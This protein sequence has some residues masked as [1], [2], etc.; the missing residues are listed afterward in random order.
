MHLPA[1]VN[2]TDH[3]LSLAG[4]KGV[5]L[6]G[7]KHIFPCSWLLL[8]ATQDTFQHFG[9]WHVKCLFFFKIPKTAKEVKAGLW[10]AVGWKRRKLKSLKVV[11]YQ[12][13]SSLTTEAMLGVHSSEHT[14][15]ARKGE[16]RLDIVFLHERVLS[17]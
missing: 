17:L 8:S 7:T 2:F 5:Q 16:Q 9:F 12:K 4:G 14:H 15:Q 6:A 3:H 10:W 13:N 11:H 1:S